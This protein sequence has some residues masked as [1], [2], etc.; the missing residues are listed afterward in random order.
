MQRMDAVS[1]R[2][3]EGVKILRRYSASRGTHVLDPVLMADPSVLGNLA[4]K[5]ARKE[6]SPYIATYIL[7]PDGKKREALLHVSKKL[8]RKLV[9]MLDGWYNKFAQNK[10]ALN[11]PNTVEQLQVEEWLGYFKTATS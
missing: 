4:D 9:N 7:D 6:E 10:K 2:E 1:V 3:K 5:A 8:N 11:L